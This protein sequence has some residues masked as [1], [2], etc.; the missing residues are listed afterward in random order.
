MK[1]TNEGEDVFI[2]AFVSNYL[3]NTVNSI[4]SVLRGAKNKELLIVNIKN[5][6]VKLYAD[7]E[8]IFLNRFVENALRGTVEGIVSSLTDIK[9]GK[10]IRL[11]LKG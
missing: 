7:G 2:N 5:K 8:D 11:A 4:V 1:L 9:E 10:E 6:E 3:Y